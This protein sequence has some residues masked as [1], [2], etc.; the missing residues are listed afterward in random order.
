MDQFNLAL[1]VIAGTVLAAGILSQP[2]KRSLLQEPLVAVLVGIAAGPRVAGLI[3]LNLLERPLALLEEAARITV[4]IA[5]M[6]VALRVEPKSMFR[7]KAPAL[8][9]VTL[10]MLGM[11]L[12]STLLMMWLLGLPFWVAALLG[13]V[14]TPTDPVVASAIVTGP[15]ARKN[16][17]ERLRSTLSLESG[18]NDGLAY[19][20]VLLP[21]L[22]LSMAPA[23]AVR[24]WA[25]DTLLTG[26]V[27]ACLLGLLVGWSAAKL[28][29]WAERRSYIERYSYLTFTL[30]VS[31]F[32]LGVGHVI[33]AE[34]LLSVFVA[35]LAFDVWSDT[36]ERHDEER[37]QEGIGK[38]C[39][40]PVFILFGAALPLEAWRDLGWPLILLCLA[41]LLLR[42][43]PVLLA[44]WPLLRRYL[45][46]SDVAFLGWFG[47]IG[48]A[49]LFYAAYA[50]GQTGNGL[51]WDVGSAI[52]FASV[53]AHGVTAAPF[54]RLY[55][56]WN[57]RHEQ[58][59][60]Q[61]SEES[62]R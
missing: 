60:R 29:H 10:C 48:V 52:V 57:G 61:G 51:F 55:G 21:V 37:V 1:A 49:A 59:L 7:L 45:T 31:F 41:V 12:L 13:A 6:A 58:K 17:P 9:L 33:G 16:L 4:A 22:L 25:V 47:P 62:A 14:V 56:A 3:D 11:W 34:S 26:V 8:I 40:L 43:P 50:T 19:L 24:H 18:A 32:T 20:L 44:L 36:R 38:L 39:T 5:L 42:R 15:L 28:L 30:A 46:G 2:L 54:C 53:I 35:G 23:Q 27:L